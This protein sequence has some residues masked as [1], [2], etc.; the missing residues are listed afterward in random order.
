[1]VLISNNLQGVRGVGASVGFEGEIAA[2][3]NHTQF[4]CNFQVLPP[5]KVGS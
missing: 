1:M 3:D 5:F 2:R 4:Y